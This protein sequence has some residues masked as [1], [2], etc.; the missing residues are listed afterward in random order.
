MAGSGQ[1]DDFLPGSLLGGQ[2]ELFSF[3]TRPSVLRIG[4]VALQTSAAEAFL[5]F[6]AAPFV[7]LK[8]GR[9]GPGR[10]FSVAAV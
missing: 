5:D 8:E 4:D 9:G 2:E 1:Q 3:E 10:I 7:A 6:L